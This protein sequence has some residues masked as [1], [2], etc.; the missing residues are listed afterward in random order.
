LAYGDLLNNLLRQVLR[1]IGH[2]SQTY[3][4]PLK[5][6]KRPVSAVNA[7]QIDDFN[8]N[9]SPGIGYACYGWLKTGV[10]ISW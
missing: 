7:V 1:C 9:M 6:K 8:R 2:L 5:H 3:Y 10:L 4:Y